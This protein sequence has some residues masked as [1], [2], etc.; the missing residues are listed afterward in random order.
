MKLPQF[1]ELSNKYGDFYIH[2]LDERTKGS[3]RKSL[4]FS[5]VTSDLTTPYIKNKLPKRMPKVAENEVLMWNWTADRLLV[6]NVGSIIRITSMS[7]ELRKA[8]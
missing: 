8:R 4:S 5:V 7:Q 2:Y 1:N 6:M 3:S